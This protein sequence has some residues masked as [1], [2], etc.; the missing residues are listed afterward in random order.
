MRKL[1]EYG[2]IASYEDF[3]RLPLGVIQ[4]ALLVIEAEGIQAQTRGRRGH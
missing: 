2:L 1:H 3:L 4:D